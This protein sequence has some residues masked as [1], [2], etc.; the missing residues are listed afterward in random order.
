IDDELEIKHENIVL[1][2]SAFSEDINSDLNIQQRWCNQT[3]PITINELR[4]NI[5]DGLNEQIH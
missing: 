4:L 3:F 5:F 1:L 2:P